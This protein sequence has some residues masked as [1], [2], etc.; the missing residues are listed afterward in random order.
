VSGRRSRMSRDA[1]TTVAG[2]PVR[3]TGLGALGSG[4]QKG[5]LGLLAEG[6]LGGLGAPAV[7]AFAFASLLAFAPL[8]TAV[9]SIMTSC[10][11]G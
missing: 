10:A 4:G 9:I 5:G 3:L 1:S 2:A 8:I 11:F 7:L 6:L